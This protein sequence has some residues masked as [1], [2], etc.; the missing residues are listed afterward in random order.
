MLACSDN[1]TKAMI[2]L[3]LLTELT[4]FP[5]SRY[6]LL[7]MGVLQVTAVRQADVGGF[8]CVATNIA[9]TRYS[10]EAILNITGSWEK[11]NGVTVEPPSLIGNDLNT[12]RFQEE[13][14]EPTRSRSSCRDLRI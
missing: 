10:H 11:K 3:G 2:R 13:P 4:L 14:R 1:A 8:R 5:R 12:T 9:N 7:P 6:T